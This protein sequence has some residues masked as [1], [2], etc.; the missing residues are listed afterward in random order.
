[1]GPL[2]ELDKQVREEQKTLDVL[3]EQV[4]PVAEAVLVDYQENVVRGQAV[5]EIVKKGVVHPWRRIGL[6]E[7]HAASEV[8][9]DCV[10]VADGHDPAPVF[11]Y[12]L[13][14]AYS[15]LGDLRRRQEAVRELEPVAAMAL[16]LQ[17]GHG[18]EW[19]SEET[20]L[21]AAGRL[22]KDAAVLPRN[23]FPN[24]TRRLWAEY[25]WMLEGDPRQPRF[26]YV[27]S[28]RLSSWSEV[29]QAYLDARPEIARAIGEQH[30][31]VGQSALAGPEAARRAG[32]AWSTWR[33]YA[34]AG[35]APAA[36]LTGPARWWPLT[37]DA[38]RI[39]TG[40]LVVGRPD[41]AG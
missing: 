35:T 29:A 39:A 27:P 21:Q 18:M 38:W 40:R 41:P 24:V 17:L 28:P 6:L 37:V 26:S 14:D 34:S 22:L 25:T 36:D 7:E 16:A 31:D 32:V 1:M 13:S 20:L 4:R 30:V 23:F 3:I 5:Y 33:A 10:V 12:L 15:F 9:E 2:H 8:R 11:Q 19:A